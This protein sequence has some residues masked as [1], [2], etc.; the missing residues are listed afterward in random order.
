MMELQDSIG[1]ISIYLVSGAA[2][3]VVAT[4]FATSLLPG[5]RTRTHEADRRLCLDDM[6]AGVLVLD[7]QSMCTAYAGR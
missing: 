1:A 4:V 7:R 2:L 5:H 3:L 6:H